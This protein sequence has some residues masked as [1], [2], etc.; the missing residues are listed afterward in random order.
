MPHQSRRFFLAGTGAAALGA[1]A[2]T[3]APAA[4]LQAIPEHDSGSDVSSDP[5]VAQVTD[6]ASG[7]IRIMQGD[8]EYDV[9]DRA[10]ARR[11]AKSVS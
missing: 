6:V 2:L 9:T 4:G 11:I 3:S 5:I 10:L 7:R 8:H 1:V